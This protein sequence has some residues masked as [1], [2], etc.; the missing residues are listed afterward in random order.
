MGRREHNARWTDR[1]KAARDKELYDLREYLQRA[2]Y[3]SP[4]TLT[5][6]MRLSAFL[7][8]HDIRDQIESEP[9]LAA[10]VARVAD[11]RASTTRVFDVI[12]QMPAATVTD[13]ENIVARLRALPAYI[14]Q[15]IGADRRSTSTR[16]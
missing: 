1:S 4:G 6:S 16:A 13:Y 7:L 15:T 5:P 10:D 14:D 9:Y 8:E 12:D 2:M 3:F 11:A